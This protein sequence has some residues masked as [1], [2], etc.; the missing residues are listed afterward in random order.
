[1]WVMRNSLNYMFRYQVVRVNILFL[2]ALVIAVKIASNSEFA[3]SP[4]I[5]NYTWVI[6]QISQG[7]CAVENGMPLSLLAKI[8]CKNS[9]RGGSPT[10]WLLVLWALRSRKGP[11]V[12]PCA[13]VCL[14]FFVVF[15][16]ESHCVL[17]CRKA[18]DDFSSSLRAAKLLVHFMNGTFALLKVFIFAISTK[19][20]SDFLKNIISF[21]WNSL[22]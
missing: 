4:S 20:Q 13:C 2:L 12:S 6:L 17:Q 7:Y 19:I 10:W 14:G 5:F 16:S 11:I 15:D 1:M 18:N 9:Y 3:V 21:H 8:N 22:H